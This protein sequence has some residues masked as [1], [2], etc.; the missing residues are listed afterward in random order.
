MY[1]CDDDWARGHNCRGVDDLMTEKLLSS[2]PRTL[3][4]SERH[5]AIRVTSGMLKISDWGS[6]LETRHDIAP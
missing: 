2:S 3:Y 4:D 5:F 6:E 1:Q